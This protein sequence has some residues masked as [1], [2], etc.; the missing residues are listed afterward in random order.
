LAALAVTT[1]RIR[2]GSL[3]NCIFYRSP[4]LL[5][6]MAADV[7]R[8]SAGRLVLGLG[9]GDFAEEFA[10]LGITRPSTQDR[11]AGLDEVIAII[12]GIWGSAPAPPPGKHFGISTRV[13]GLGPVQVPR[14]PFLIAGG[15]ERVT[16][17]QVAQH[18]DASNFGEHAWIGAVRSDEDLHRR[19]DALRHH[20]ASFDRPY[21]SVLRTHSAV[22]LVIAETRAALPEKLERYLPDV[23]WLTGESALIGTPSDII[24]HY[25]RLIRA[26]VQYFIP[27]VYGNDLG[28]VRL[29][30]ERVIPELPDPRQ[31]AIA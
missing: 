20:C 23:P 19:W 30:A 16:L 28:T 2:L 14:I 24:A 27:F 10:Q 22:P 15:G 26:G 1:R 13:L 17:R 8:M 29:L 4:A 21:E 25:S 9:I 11:Q 6:R 3:V 5:A 31:M 7:D 12:R 18:A